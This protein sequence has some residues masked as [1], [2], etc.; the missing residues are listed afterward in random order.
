MFSQH[1]DRF[2]RLP[3]NIQGAAWLLLGGLCYTVVS[4]LIKYLCQSLPFN[5]VAFFRCVL[6]LVIILPGLLRH[7]F[8]QM[9]SKRHLGHLWRAILGTVSM[10]VGFYVLT[11]LALADATAVGF[12][13]PLFVI[14]IAAAVLREKIRW[15]RWSATAI[16][17]IGVLIMMRPGSHGFD[18]VLLLALFGAFLTAAAVCVVK[19]LT[20][21]ENPSTMLVMMTVWGAVFLLIPAIVVWQEPSWTEWGLALAMGTMA[22]LGQ[23]CIIRAYTAGEA[24][25][26]A[27]FDYLRLPFSVMV[28]FWLFAETPSI[29]TLVGALVIVSSTLYIARREAQLGKTVEPI[30]RSQKIP[31]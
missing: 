23:S 11:K 9:K 24:T 15:R 3:G 5:E 16:G 1:R 26:V 19:S 13:A 22:T 10:L 18:P 25:A 8:A 2:S 21:S 31:T 17:F 14:I 4:A 28:G 7:R 27:P 30:A 6:G 20:G 12:T 29:W